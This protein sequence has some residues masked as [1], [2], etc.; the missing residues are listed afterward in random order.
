MGGTAVPSRTRSVVIASADSN[1]N[2]SRDAMWEQ[3]IDSKPS[4]S[5]R[6]AYR[7]AD[8]NDAVAGVWMLRRGG[9]GPTWAPA[10]R[11][12][13]SRATP[14]PGSAEGPRPGASGR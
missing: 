11:L 13:G 1:V 14:A 8:G 5:A 6:P 7:T 3:L 10:T 12:H 9:G 4:S 2:E